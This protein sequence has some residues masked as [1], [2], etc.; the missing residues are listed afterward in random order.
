MRSTEPSF[1]RRVVWTA[2]LLVLLLGYSLLCL[3]DLLLARWL[4]RQITLANAPARAI[5]L[6]R[7]AQ[8]DVAQLAAARAS[9]KRTMLFPA[10]FEQEAF[11]AIVRRH[12]VLPLGT[13]PS[14]SLA[15]CNEGAGLVTYASDRFGFR[16][17]DAAWDAPTVTV[18]LLGD[19][20]VQGACVADQDTIA[21]RLAAA[22]HTV[23][24]LGTSG[25][26]G[27]MHAAVARAFLPV[28]RPRHAVMVFY[29]NDNDDE[30]DSA[31][32]A[33]A[34]PESPDYV[35]REGA[36][37]RPGPAYQRLVP[38][39]AEG[40]A[41]A[42]RQVARSAG[43]PNEPA[44]PGEAADVR[45]LP[46]WLALV[47]LRTVARS[48]YRRLTGGALPWSSR[49]AIDTLAAH[50]QS[51]GCQP[52]LVYIPN[53]SFWR[54]DPRGDSYRQALKAYANRRYPSM[55]W[56]DTSPDLAELGSTAYA[57]MGGHLSAAGYAVVARA[58]ALQLP[59]DSAQ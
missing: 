4:D 3:A 12:G 17:P 20:F 55:P 37:L 29:A 51:V 22:G 42:Q 28:L 32:R 41:E 21:A 44:G 7:A 6:R 36:R 46:K 38:V 23:V 24:S 30:E 26:N 34:L 15:Y 47:T 49:L 45:R 25:N 16:N 56:I 43:G 33:L 50:C 57:S 10:L 18:A 52:V 59:P 35:V 19:S 13:Q 27:L 14:A 1:R 48:G 58:I 39:W 53:S 8:Q 9:G 11:Q 5:E 40:E 54:P 31:L 2:G